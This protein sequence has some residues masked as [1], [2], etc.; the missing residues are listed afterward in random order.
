MC[1]LP[2]Q[3]DRC[4]YFLKNSWLWGPLV[5]LRILFVRVFLAVTKA[6]V[7]PTSQ[8]SA[9]AVLLLMFILHTDILS[10][11]LLRFG[12]FRVYNNNEFIDYMVRERQVQCTSHRESFQN[13]LLEPVVCSKA[14]TSFT[15]VSGPVQGTPWSGHHVSCHWW[16]VWGMTVRPVLVSRPSDSFLYVHICTNSRQRC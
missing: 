4:C 3:V 12:Y 16:S 6:L 8:R 11:F 10:I 5:A 9:V 14:V 7:S 15:D 1:C 13:C 2:Y